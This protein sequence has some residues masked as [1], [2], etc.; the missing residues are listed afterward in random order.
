MF[1][2]YWLS[3]S[4]PDAALGALGWALPLLYRAKHLGDGCCEAVVVR[5]WHVPLLHDSISLLQKL[6]LKRSGLGLLLTTCLT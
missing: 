5:L 2:G 6:L 4:L 3:G 1:V